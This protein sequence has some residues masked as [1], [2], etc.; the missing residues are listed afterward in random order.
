[1]EPAQLFFKCSLLVD[2]FK[3]KDGVFSNLTNE[4]LWL[5]DIQHNIWFLSL[6]QTIQCGSEAG[7][8]ARERVFGAL[9]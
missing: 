2:A 6:L 1:M 7:R 8:Y 9:Q 4:G 5:A 3:E